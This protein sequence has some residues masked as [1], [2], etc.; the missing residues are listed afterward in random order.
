MRPY[1]IIV[2]EVDRRFRIIG[3]LTEF[4]PVENKS[5]DIWASPRRRGLSR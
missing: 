3:R 5:W 2:G 1:S 4:E